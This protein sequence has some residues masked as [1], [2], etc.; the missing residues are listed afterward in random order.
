MDQRPQRGNHNK[1]PPAAAGGSDKKS[2]YRCGGGHL[3]S[4]CPCREYVCH[5]CKKKGHLS[6]MCRKKGKGSKPKKEEEAKVLV[7]EDADTMDHVESGSRKP[8]RTVVNVNG[9]SLPM[10]I[11][12]GASVS[13]I[14]KQ[15]FESLR[16]GVSTLELQSTAVNLKTYTGES[17]AV[18]GSVLVAVE[19]RGQT[20]NLPLIVTQAEGSPL[21]GRDW[22]SALRLDWKTIF[23]VSTMLSLQQILDKYNGVFKEGL[24]EL[25]NAKAKIYIKTNERPHFL[26]P[27]QVPFA[28]RQKVEEELE[29]LQSLGVIRPVQ[30]SDWAAPIVPVMKTNGRVR[31][32]GDYKITINRAAKIEKYPILRIKE[33][34]ASLAGGKTFSKLDLSHAYLQILLEEGS[35]R[36]VTINTHKGLFEYRRFPFGVSSAPS[37]FQRIMENLL[38]GISGVCGYS[39]NQ[40]D[41][42]RAPEQPGT[43][44]GEV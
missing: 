6:K 37:I 10:E 22:L 32:C 9:T 25:Q 44:P 28:I 34:F 41:R 5:S 3:A 29:R 11:D 42:G 13:V 35:C 20:L 12:T 23:T 31:I 2:C 27:R 14:G 33:L 30:F 19:Y 8:Y 17:I 26:L 18:L 24:G 7:D 4:K 38:Q 15:T 16:K 39:G 21:L 40:S 43:S 1:S 36:Y